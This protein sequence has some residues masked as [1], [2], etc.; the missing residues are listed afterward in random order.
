MSEKTCVLDS[1]PCAIFIA[2]FLQRA[3]I[4]LSRFHI[5]YPKGIIQFKEELTEILTLDF[6]KKPGKHSVSIVNKIARFYFFDF[7]F[8]EVSS[9]CNFASQRIVTFSISH[10][11]VFNMN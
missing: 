8:F 7:T 5:F 9:E 1:S 3:P 4:C 10:F 2:T 11:F 6:F